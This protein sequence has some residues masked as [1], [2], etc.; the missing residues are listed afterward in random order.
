M[1]DGQ[2]FTTRFFGDLSREPDGRPQNLIWFGTAALFYALAAYDFVT[3]SSITLFSPLIATGFAVGGAAESLP[4]ERR[5]AVYWTRAL[6]IVV[7]LGLFVLLLVGLLGGPE[8][9][10]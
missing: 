3:T 10:V 1:T 6:S 2:D 4:A 5:R 8:L 7:M 9:L